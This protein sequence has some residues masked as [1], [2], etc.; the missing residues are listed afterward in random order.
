MN[1]FSRLQAG[2]KE[3]GVV[4]EGKTENING[5]GVKSLVVEETMRGSW[6]LG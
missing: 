6:R 5:M 3:K 4:T 2:R 1:V